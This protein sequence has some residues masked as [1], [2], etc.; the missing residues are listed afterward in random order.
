MHNS[1]GVVD[2]MYSDQNRF[3]VCQSVV[4]CVSQTIN[5]LAEAQSVS[6]QL[7]GNISKE[8]TNFVR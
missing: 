1:F 7:K 2:G 4:D 5:I 6:L 3:F 8:D